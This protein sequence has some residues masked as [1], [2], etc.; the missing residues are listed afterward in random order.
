[1]NLL[2]VSAT[3]FEIAPIKNYLKENFTK[4]S[5]GVFEKNNLEISILITGVGIPFTSLHL[6]RIFA[7]RQYDLA[8]NAGIAG[9]FNR[10]LKIGDVVNV[11]SERFGDLGVEEAD[12]QFTDMHEL[13]LI[14]GNEFPFENGELLN[15][16]S[17]SLNE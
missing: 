1:M 13:G 5:E 14:E 16:N 15:E 8:L 12:G 3:P 17:L 7:Q 10:E 9:A 6:G 2:L 11:I 4:K